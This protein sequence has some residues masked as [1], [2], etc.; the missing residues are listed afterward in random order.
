[1]AD[2]V[3]WEALPKSQADSET[4]AAAINAAMASHNL[5]P[6]AHMEAGASLAEHRASEIL[7]HLEESIYN[8]KLRVAARAYVAIVDPSSD[9]DFATVQ[10]AHGYAVTKGGGSILIT[11]GDH[12]ITGEFL[13]SSDVNFVGID[14]DT[15]RVHAGAT[16]ADVVRYPQTPLGS[17]EISTWQSIGIVDDGNGFMKYDTA[18]DPGENW[19]VFDDCKFSGQGKY[20]WA[21]TF[22]I[23]VRNCDIELAGT[24]GAFQCGLQ[25]ELNNNHIWT[26]NVAGTSK[27]FTDT[28]GHFEDWIRMINNYGDG[29]GSVAYKLFNNA[30]SGQ[31]WMGNRFGV[32]TDTYINIFSG[33][34]VANQMY[35]QSTTQFEIRGSG[36]TITGNTIG[37][38]S[39]N[40]ILIPSGNDENI[41]TGNKLTV[42]LDDQGTNNLCENNGPEASYLVVANTTTACN[43]RKNKTVE[44]TPNSTRTL[45]TNV[46]AKG[47]RRCLRIKTSGTTSYTLTF[48]TG[49]KTTGTLATGTTTSRQFIIEFISDGTNLIETSRTAAFAI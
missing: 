7:D 44:L 36:N 45:T 17:Q 47:T 1:M 43:F 25:L 34:M 35:N 37:S 2:P 38:N 46:P 15:C 9:V 39:T 4:I 33:V 16:A 12:Y 21:A 19:L 13:V 27:L 8:D 11:Q 18:E 26:A 32:I 14:R 42:G 3:T 22:R 41:V 31:I 10:E 28:G 24:V 23:I 5:D 40:P 30:S 6:H 49:F 29:D 48:G 20:C